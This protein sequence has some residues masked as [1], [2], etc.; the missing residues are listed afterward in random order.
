[1]I[2]V[3]KLLF[4]FILSLFLLTGCLST[5][6]AEQREKQSGK[7]DSIIIGIPVPREF[8][9][10][11]T[12]FLKGIQ[13][14]VEDI[15]AQGVNNKKIKLEIVD[16]KGV[17]KDAVDIAQDFSENPRM[18]AVIGHWFSDIAIP[19]SSIYEKAGMLV[20][21]PTV[22][23]PELVDKDYRY[24]FQNIPSDKKVAEKMCR[25]AEDK[26]YK[27]M[28]IY[29][30]DSSYGRNLADAFE[31]EAQGKGLEI[32]DRRSGLVGE[33]DFKRTYEKW[34]ALNFDSVFLALNMP[35][36]AHFIKQFRKLDADTAILSG[37]GLN[38]SNFIEVMGEDAEDVVIATIY[39]PNNKRAQLKEFKKRYKQKYSGEPDV[40][41]IQG[42]DSLMLIARAIEQTDSCSPAVLASYLRDVK[43]M[44]LVS[45]NIAFN[46]LGEIQGREVYKKKV[47][48]GGFVYID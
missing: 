26:G 11:N 27:N 46:D 35:E 29:Y 13:L 25:Y 33:I 15:N 43:A 2:K 31:E 10:N 1:M 41:A 9:E 28:V 19:V 38:V 20:V 37:D 48:N 17:F 34:N 44:K 3:L 12:G 6:L 36:G 42:Y 39:N 4:I 45:G 23:N 8:A 22:S 5:D 24:I 21:V 16:D 7:G 30:E 18:T 32:V 14:A 40:W 47:V